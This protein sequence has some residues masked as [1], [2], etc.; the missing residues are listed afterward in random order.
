[1]RLAHEH[2]SGRRPSAGH[3]RGPLNINGMDSP[4]LTTGD[5][6]EKATDGINM[7]GEWASKFMHK[8]YGLQIVSSNTALGHQ[9]SEPNGKRIKYL[10]CEGI[11]FRRFA[12]IRGAKRELDI[13]GSFVDR[14]L[15]RMP[16]PDEDLIQMSL[17]NSI[18]V[19]YG[20][21]FSS[22]S[23]NR[24]SPDPSAI[25]TSEEYEIHKELI[26]IRNTVIAHSGD[27]SHERNDI[28]FMLDDDNYVTGYLLNFI[29]IAF[30]SNEILNKVKEM[31]NKI[32]QFYDDKSRACM[33][34]IY[35]QVLKENQI[36]STGEVE[37]KYV[38]N[39]FHSNAFLYVIK[40]ESAKYDFSPFKLIT[41]EQDSPENE[42]EII[43]TRA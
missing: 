34:A 32:S 14:S 39:D 16:L 33:D 30:S 18:I 43:P 41:S 13:L 27:N 42:T 21:I 9:S 12:E 2:A 26:S 1:M 23:R 36:L 8:H 20:K 25:F 19:L 37:E 3:P 7:I 35:K 6:M 15:L 31:V 10:Q 40:L 4:K 11:I 24:P 28:H 5:T 22:N 17:F 29:D 38:F